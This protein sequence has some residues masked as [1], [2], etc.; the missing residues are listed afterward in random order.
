MVRA[1]HAL[2]DVDPDHARA[3]HGAGQ[4]AHTLAFLSSAA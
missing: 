3:A 1:D 4:V 2:L